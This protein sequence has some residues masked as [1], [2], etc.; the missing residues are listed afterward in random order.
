M[1]DGIDTSRWIEYPVKPDESGMIMDYVGDFNAK[2]FSDDNGPF[3]TIDS[4]G[5]MV[6]NKKNARQYGH[7]DTAMDAAIA[8]EKEITRRYG[9]ETAAYQRPY[10]VYYDASLKIWMVVGAGEPKNS[11]VAYCGGG[12]VT[13]MITA[14]KGEILCCRIAE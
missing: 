7:I 5:N 1:P 2:V 13:A 11:D 8:V 4:N 14:E 10:T 9:Q 6:S 3:F 12:W